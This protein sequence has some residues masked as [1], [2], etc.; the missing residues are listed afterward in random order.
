MKHPTNRQERLKVNKLKH[1]QKESRPYRSGR[2][3]AQEAIKA[4]ELD[5]EL[6]EAKA[7][8]STED[9]RAAG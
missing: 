3:H 5:H 6:R 7:N 2:R 9:S 8:P 1:E 4:E